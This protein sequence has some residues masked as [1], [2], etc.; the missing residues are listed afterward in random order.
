MI[1]TTIRLLLDPSTNHWIELHSPQALSTECHYIPRLVREAIE[2]A[3]C[4]NFNREE[5]F[6]LSSAWNTSIQYY[7]K[8]GQQPTS[9]TRT[10]V[11]TVSLVCR[12]QKITSSANLMC[13]VNADS[14]SYRRI[15]KKVDRY[16][17]L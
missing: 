6:K 4:K 14:S 9:S 1:L 3:K 15:R 10:N 8:T 11:D 2:I 16:G 7:N 12:Q 17:Y 13:I 5:G